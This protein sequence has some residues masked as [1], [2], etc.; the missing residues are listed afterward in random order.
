MTRPRTDRANARLD[1][2]PAAGIATACADRLKMP[3]TDGILALAKGQ[4]SIMTVEN[5]RKRHSIPSATGIAPASPHASTTS[6]RLK[7]P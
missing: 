6:A 7:N 5:G 1:D 2:W 4:T 3:R